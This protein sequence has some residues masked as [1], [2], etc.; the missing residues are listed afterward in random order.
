[1]NKNSQ[2]RRKS[3]GIFAIAL[4]LF[5]VLFC[6]IANAIQLD[7]AVIYW[8]ENGQNKS[9]TKYPGDTYT[10]SCD[11]S[12]SVSTRIYKRSDAPSTVKYQYIDMNNSDYKTVS[13]TDPSYFFPSIAGPLDTQVMIGMYDD[14]NSEQVR[15]YVNWISPSKPDLSVSNTVVDGN[16]SPSHPFVVGDKVKVE[17]IVWNRGDSTSGSSHVGY[18]IGNSSTDTS[19]RWESDYV[20]S[21]GKDQGS[22]AEEYYTFKSSDVGTNKYFIFKADYRDEVDEGNNEGNNLAAWGPFTVKQGNT[23]PTVNVTSPSHDITVNSG[24][25]VTIAWDGTDPDSAAEVAIMYDEDNDPNNTNYHLIQRHLSEDGNLSWDTTNVPA[26]TYYILALIDDTIC[27]SKA[28][29][30]GKV[31]IQQSDS[32]HAQ[33]IDLWPIDKAECGKTITLRA[34]VKNTGSA[35]LPSNA[36][37]R[38]WVDGPNWSGDHWVGSV[39]VAGLADGASDSYTYRWTVPSNLSK[40]NYTYMAQVWSGGSTIS[41]WSASQDFTI[42]CTGEVRSGKLVFASDRDG[43]WDIFLMSVSKDGTTGTALNL[44]SDLSGNCMQ[45]RWSPDGNKIA[46]RSNNS[47]T[48]QIWVMNSDGSNKVRVTSADGYYANWPV[49]SPDGSKIAFYRHKGTAT[50][51]AY[52]TTEICV[53]NADGSGLVCYGNTD[54]H[55]EYSPSW[56]PDGTKLLYDRDEKTCNNPKDLWIMDADGSNRHLFYPPSGQDNDGLYQAHSHWGG[57][58]KIVFDEMTSW[59]NWALSIINSDGTG[60]HRIEIGDIDKKT[61]RASCWA[62]GGE[63]I[64]YS[65]RKQGESTH[66][67]MINEDG[68]GEVQLTLGAS[69]DAQADF[70][71]A[72]SGG[73]GSNTLSVSTE[74]SGTITSSP[75]GINCG[76]DCS[77]KYAKGTQVTLTA[78]P[79]EGYTFAGWGGDCSKCG[80]NPTCTLTMDGDKQ[81]TARFTACKIKVTG[82]KMYINGHR[83]KMKSPVFIDGVDLNVKFEPEI[84]WGEETPGTVRF[85]TPDNIWE[86]SS[87]ETKT[88]NV[89][90][91][92]GVGG[93]LKIL[94][95]SSNGIQSNTY[96]VPFSVAPAPLIG[97]SRFSFDEDTNKYT[98]LVAMIFGLINGDVGS[99]KTPSTFPI[100]GGKEIG[101]NLVPNV[102]MEIN[103]AGEGHFMIGVKKGLEGSYVA[104]AGKRVPVVE[105]PKG[106]RESIAN[107]CSISGDLGLGLVFKYEDSDW[108]YGGL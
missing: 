26:G 108:N 45:P 68:T 88:F 94:A 83:I 69:N 42:S 39:S 65:A 73:S 89:G 3:W 41:A 5:F 36:Q 22:N 49:W 51:S 105:K 85:I 46:F 72:G 38:F 106:A 76:G 93:K 70:F 32:V 62:F 101:F 67:W 8:V 71:A 59:D 40:G 23:C 28:Y 13:S 33:V 78:T 79:G 66:L 81:C 107:R 37:V 63:K 98:T 64:I 24:D 20:P 14:R 11:P 30:A 60:Y 17:C 54:G 10:I 56:S 96:E 34:K 47:G 97:S 92:F 100:F 31:T 16:L 95:V 104:Y 1:M 43:E 7:H 19:N 74:G 61:L 82:V 75:A 102:I 90:N 80:K 15:L 77:E 6:G 86:V 12:T 44:T 58:G 52:R 103:L 2:G 25:K 18:Y 91:E 21:L 87:G 84:E 35:P 9:V 27:S 50:C 4:F 55:G 53:M 99:S 48:D 57:H 29:A